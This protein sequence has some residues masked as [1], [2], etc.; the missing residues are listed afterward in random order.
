MEKK[1]IHD[2]YKLILS[3]RDDGRHGVGVVLAPQIASYVELRDNT[4]L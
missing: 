4:R 1:I 2:N 3:G